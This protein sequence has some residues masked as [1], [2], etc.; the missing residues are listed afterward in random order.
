MTYYEISSQESRIKHQ[1]HIINQ[2]SSVYQPTTAGH[3]FASLIELRTILRDAFGAVPYFAGPK[4]IE[5]DWA[6]GKV[7]HSPSESTVDGRHPAPVGNA[8]SL[9]CTVKIKDW[10]TSQLQ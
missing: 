6:P 7:W 10:K 9:P 1:S 4:W 8:T 2:I 5:V 3:A